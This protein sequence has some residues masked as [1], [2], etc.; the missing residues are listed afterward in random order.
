MLYCRQQS[1]TGYTLIEIMVAMVILGILAAIAIPAYN[2]Y[3]RTARMAEGSDSI[4]LL[5]LA[6]LEFFEE[7]GNFFIGASTQQLIN[8]SNRRWLPTPWDPTLTDAANIANLNFSYAVTNCVL[9]NGGGAGA[10]NAAGD[11]TQCYTVTATGQNMLTNADV[12][13]DSN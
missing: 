2:G 8:N 3:I 13:T 5:H 6:Q 4:A 10:T 7:S 12:L 9:G 1:H 11:P